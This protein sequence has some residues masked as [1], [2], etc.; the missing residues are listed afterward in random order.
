M[1]HLDSY[2]DLSNFSIDYE[3]LIHRVSRIGYSTELKTILAGMLEYE[4]DLRFGLISCQE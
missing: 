4:P 2:Y 3:S 1:E